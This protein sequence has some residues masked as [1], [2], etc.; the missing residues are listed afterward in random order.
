[1]ARPKF[2]AQ[3]VSRR[4]AARERLRLPTALL[5]I[6]SSGEPSRKRL[7]S[8]EPEEDYDSNTNADVDWPD[9]RG[10]VVD[11]NEVLSHCELNPEDT[12][13]PI[14]VDFQELQQE[15]QYNDPDA[16]LPSIED[17]IPTQPF[18]VSDT[19]GITTPAES[20]AA[21][22]GST[23]SIPASYYDADGSEPVKHQRSPFEGSKFK[24]A[25]AFWCQEAG[26][27]RTQYTAL[28][29]ILRM[30][31]RSGMME[32]LAKL[33]SC[34]STLKQQTR[35]Q[36]P[37]LQLRRKRIPLQ[38]DMV[39]GTSEFRTEE[40][41]YFFDAIQLTRIILSSDLMKKMH[42][43]FGEFHDAP[44]ELWHGHGWR[45]SI[46]TTSGQFVYHQGE[47]VFPSDFIDFVCTDIT[48]EE[49][50]L[51]H[52]RHGHLCTV[53][54]C[55]RAYSPTGSYTILERLSLHSARTDTSNPAIR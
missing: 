14:N 52:S 29:E 13:L 31:S 3:T 36:L 26:I 34:L 20:G 35:A 54:Y 40:D 11:I 30:G 37:L 9:D 25:L 22:D 2:V 41:L 48:C 7:Q 47:P 50:D 46:R 19:S 12:Q 33:P 44:T 32:E 15:D 51:G 6:E 8:E 45:S 43:G 39:A 27:S 42:F 16:V 49:L 23:T 17:D 55:L 10:S 28:L 38:P 21:M 18:D 1:M 53:K 24:H 5:S 4:T